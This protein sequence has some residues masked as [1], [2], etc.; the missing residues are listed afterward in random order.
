MGRSNEPIR[1]L[2]GSPIN[3][4]IRVLFHHTISRLSLSPLFTK[5][6]PTSLPGFWPELFRPS[7]FSSV[8]SGRFLTHVDSSALAWGDRVIRCVIQFRRE[9][10]RARSRSGHKRRDES[11]PSPPRPWPAPP[12]L[13]TAQ[14]LP[15]TPA[16]ARRL[17]RLPVSPDLNHAR[18]VDSFSCIACS[19]NF[20]VTNGYPF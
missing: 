15:W 18:F 4:W 2:T 9:I 10:Y 6:A 19:R 8:F 7:V 13:W 3:K 20:R 5:S 11:I 17:L 12:P 14:L 1:G 16:A